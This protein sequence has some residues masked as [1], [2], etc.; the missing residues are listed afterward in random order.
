MV[1]HISGHALFLFLNFSF[2]GTSY[3]QF[4]NELDFS[5]VSYPV[6]MDDILRFEEDNP[7]IRINIFIHSEGEFFPGHTTSNSTGSR[8]VGINIVQN[9]ALE[10]DTAE[11]S[12]H[13]YPV[14]NLTKFSQR[15]Y[16]SALSGIRSYSHTISCDICT[17][18]FKLHT[19]QKGRKNSYIIGNGELHLGFDDLNTSQAYINHRIV[20]EQGITTSIISL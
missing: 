10:W 13:F 14:V 15:V 12:E 20:C 3:D 9:T 1:N 17:S 5:R 19:N 6:G 2:V 7:S 8:S 4:A 16:R 18:T 11:I